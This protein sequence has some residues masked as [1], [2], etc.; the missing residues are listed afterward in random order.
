MGASGRHRVAGIDPKNVLDGYRDR[1]LGE[2]SDAEIFDQ[3][4]PIV[5]RPPVRGLTSFTLHVPLEVMGRYGLMRL[6]DPAD[7]E[8]A[9]LQMVATASVYGH[10]VNPMPAPARAHS[11]TT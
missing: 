6:V 5:A 1:A 3:V 10:H 9:R 4:S 7:R 8:L 2:L 11:H